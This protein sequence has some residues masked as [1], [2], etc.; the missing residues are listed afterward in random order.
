MYLIDNYEATTTTAISRTDTQVQITNATE[1]LSTNDYTLLA[2]VAGRKT[3]YV[4]AKRVTSTTHEIIRGQDGTIGRPWEVGT[5]I[6]GAVTALVLK[7]I[8][9]SQGALTH[10]FG[11]VTPDNTGAV[12][13][14]KVGALVAV[15]DQLVLPDKTVVDV[16]SVTDD[17]NIVITGHVADQEYAGLFEIVLTN[18]HVVTYWD[19]VDNVWRV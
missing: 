6:I 5:K 8:G 16:S 18:N 10:V 17:D 3:E 9:K 2:F 14:R 12:Y 1:T 7:Q 15:G 4:W 13:L 19:V 11:T